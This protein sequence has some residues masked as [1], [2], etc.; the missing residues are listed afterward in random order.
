LAD[1][2]ATARVL[3]LVNYRPEY[4]HAWGT[5]SYYTQ[6]RLDPLGKDSAEEMLAALLGDGQDLLPLK[7][8]V[9]DKTQG[10]PFF[11]EEMVQA[12]F[13]QGA[14]AR[15][16]AVK[17]ARPVTEVRIPATVQGILSSRIDRLAAPD[18][19]LLQTLAVIGKEF[20]L[21]LIR[22]VTNM[23]ED[24]LQRSLYSLQLAEFIYE[25]PAFPDLEYTFKHAL[26]L[27]VAYNSILSERRKSLHERI[28]ASIE[29]QFAG[30]L[31]DHFGDLARHYSRSGR[32]EKA[33]EYL[34]LAANQA[35][36]R[37]Y[38][39][40]A[41]ALVTQALDLLH[42]LPDSEQ[43]D[44][45]ELQLLATLGVSLMAARGF[46]SDETERVF[47]Q[48]VELARRLRD[49]ITLYTVLQGLW[50][51]HYTRGNVKVALEIAEEALA[52]AEDL[53]DAGLI[54]DAHRALGS[55]LEQTGDLRGARRHL[56]EA[57]ASTPGWQG[58]VR[59]YGPDLRVLSLSRL[60]GVLSDL[61][62]PDQGLKVAHEA[63]KAVDIKSD[64]FSMAMAMQS[65]AQVLCL[66]GQTREG[67]DAARTVVALS[68]EHGYP[69]RLS[70]GRRIQ[71]WAMMLNGRVREGLQMIERELDRTPAAQ[72][73]MVRHMALV[74]IAEG[75]AMLGDPTHGLALLD[76]WL[77]TRR[78]VETSGID[79]FYHRLRGEMLSAIGADEEAETN[80]REAIA[81]AARYGSK[82]QELLAVMSFA[83]LL[84]K[85]GRGEEARAMLAE[86]YGW[87][88][89]GFDT[90][91]LKD[92][93]ALLEE[94]GSG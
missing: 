77:D 38:Y 23:P 16:G 10:N 13:D 3:V 56:E 42:G 65:L 76:Q 33:I 93:K 89:E 21:G 74:N 85:H 27:E 50:A 57:I 88:T 14:L 84:K 58:T 80:F 82:R 12:L 40:E 87:F 25:Q 81:L 6:L 29:E 59:R 78:H 60:S 70:V 28:A 86:I 72:L 69:Y 2:L 20:P 26:T 68:E 55:S 62:Y 94:L 30:R 39:P 63:T 36:L 18:K 11:M 4:R 52:I 92:A 64:P 32:V 22:R 44:F 7:R 91:D 35:T 5:R 46:S 53:K 1:S 61:G 17:A 34:W 41:A 9:I 73:E 24:Q 8:L 47:A 90:G 51:V 31:D 83:R 49:P 48:S 79:P 75:Y 67:E 43:R 54:K 45:S 19:G 66:R 71:G 15:N 37:S